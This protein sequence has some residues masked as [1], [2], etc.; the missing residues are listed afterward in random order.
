MLGL[1]FRLADLK[2]MVTFFTLRFS[3]S[4][5]EIFS[6]FNFFC[7][8]FPSL[9]I[10]SQM[11]HPQILCTYPLRFNI[12]CLMSSD[13]YKEM[14]REIEC[15]WNKLLGDFDYAV[16]KFVSNSTCLFGQMKDVQ[17]MTGWQLLKTLMIKTSRDTHI[18]RTINTVG[19]PSRPSCFIVLG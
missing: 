1:Q 2:K 14:Y 15:I 7:D 3:I 17:W 12:F 13:W 16:F 18:L 11:I 5:L 10:V 4:F 6:V 19:I 8:I 9:S